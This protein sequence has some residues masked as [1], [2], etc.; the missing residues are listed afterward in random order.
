[1]TI[2]D[3]VGDDVRSAVIG[4]LISQRLLAANPLCRYVTLDDTAHSN[5]SDNTQA[6][7]VSAKRTNMQ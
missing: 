3:Q 6:I 1:M 7:T 5:L 2:D 4:P